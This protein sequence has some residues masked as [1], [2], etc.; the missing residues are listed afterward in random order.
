MVS[1]SAGSAFEI[2]EA[3]ATWTSVHRIL[4]QS[5]HLASVGIISLSLLAP[6]L[7]GLV[8]LLQSQVSSCGMSCCEGS[9]CCCS[10]SSKAGT[11]SGSVW[12]AAP[13]CPSGCG[14]RAGLPGSPAVTL[15]PRRVAVGQVAESV[16]LRDS[17]A[18][19]SHCADA[20]F[21]L[22]ERPPPSI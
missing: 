3:R 15:A 22:F 8:P 14:Q 6:F 4:I 2:T 9:K 19:S 5:F 11:T 13:L 1:T 18:P 16:P 10:R 21:A 12:T 17:R 7:G 20:D